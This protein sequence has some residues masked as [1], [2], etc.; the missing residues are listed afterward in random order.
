[1]AQGVLCLIMGNQN[2]ILG[3]THPLIKKNQIIVPTV[4]KSSK[5]A[6]DE[7]AA[8]TTKISTQSVVCQLVTT[9]H[10][11]SNIAGH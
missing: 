2:N 11:V 9:L 4:L 8:L 3:L 5:E 7:N 10:K 6:Q 1:M